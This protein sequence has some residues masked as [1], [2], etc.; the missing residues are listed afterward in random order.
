M[1][2]DGAEGAQHEE[3]AVR[4]VDDSER[5]KDQ[6]QAQGNEGVGAAFVQTV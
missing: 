2:G 1:E 4:E 6:R 3:G 5:A